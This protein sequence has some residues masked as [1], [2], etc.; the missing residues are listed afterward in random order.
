MPETPEIVS[1]GLQVLEQQC[2]MPRSAIAREMFVKP[3]LLD[4]LL[5][6]QDVARAENVVRLFG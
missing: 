3:K 2:G 1:D 4:R 6:V 5:G